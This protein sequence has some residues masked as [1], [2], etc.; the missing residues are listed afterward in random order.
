MELVFANENR[1]IKCNDGKIYCPNGSYTNVLWNRYLTVFD[2]IIV[3]ARVIHSDQPPLN[4]TMLASN[5][6]VL[7]ID[8]PYYVGLSQYLKK[9]GAIEQVIKKEAIKGRAYICRVPGTIGGIL[10]KYLRKREI[11]YAVEVVGDPWDVFAKGSIRHPLR[12]FIRINS[13]LSLK[14]IVNGASTSL[15]VTKD[16]LQKRYSPRSGTLTFVASNV[17]LEDAKINLTAKVFNRTEKSIVN[18]ISVGSLAQMYKSPDV[19]LKAILLLKKSGIQ[20][21]L[22]WLGDGIYRDDMVKFAE[23]LGVSDL[24]NFVGSVTSNEVRIWLNKSDLFLLV[25]RTEGLPRAVIEAMGAGL[26]CIGTR[27]GGIP[28]LLDDEALV[29]AGNEKELADKI[30]K[31]Y[32]NEQLINLQGKRNLDEAKKYTCSILNTQREYFY[33]EIKKISKT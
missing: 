8:V 28:E 29:Q 33:T 21:S 20:C 11:P 7:F 26:P 9:K 10:S 27:V 31:F 5:D 6:R 23:T 13:Y 3:V 22:T 19:V 16:T 32:N 18:I 25:S 15:Y 17:I 30:E 12:P 4:S 2:K 1:F 24:V 14:K